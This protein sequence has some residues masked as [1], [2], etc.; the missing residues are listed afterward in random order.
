[1][2][3][4]GPLTG[5][6]TQNPTLIVLFFVLL[7]FLSALGLDYIASRK[8]EKSY[9]FRARKIDK[10]ISRG[11]GILHRIVR[12]NLSE[13]GISPDSIDQYQDR[14]GALHFLIDLAQEKYKELELRLEKEFQR[15]KAAV[16]KR[17]EQKTEERDFYLWEVEGKKK[18][19]LILLFSCLKEKPLKEEKPTPE[20]EKNKV[21][22]IIDDMGYSLRAIK[23]VTA[24]GKPLTIAVLPF[25]P[26][27][28]ETAQIA[29]QN[30]LEVILHL[31]LEAINNQ[32]ANNKTEGIIHSKMSMKEVIETVDKSLDQVPYAS[33]VNNHMGSKITS[34][35]I[36]MR[37]I[38]ERLKERDL[39]FIDSRTTNHSVAYKTAQTLGIPSGYRK[40]FLDTENDE[41]FIRG[42]LIELFQRAQKEGWALGICHPTAETLKVLKEN[43]HLVDKYNLNPVFASDIVHVSTT[44]GVL[45]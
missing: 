7:A 27:A 3:K 1:M 26:L 31:P 14:E 13:L 39:F 6:I 11:E 43:I 12:D 21:A 4:R 33:G 15:A 34:N 44:A 8:G 25:S 17:E 32:E 10:E 37:I 29:H 42:K 30:G 23:E 24:I 16:T 38:L 9:I 45:E 40:I 28:K 20:E 22:I 18:E 2:Q 5:N 35:E 41:D 36:L 19:K